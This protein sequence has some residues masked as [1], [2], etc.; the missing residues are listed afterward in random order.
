MSGRHPRLFRRAAFG[1]V[2]GSPFLIALYGAGCASAGEDAT[3]TQ[4]GA[5]GE[6]GIPGVRDSGSDSPDKADAPDGGGAQEGGLDALFAPV[7]DSC[8]DTLTLAPAR[9]APAS[10]EFDTSD[11]K[12]DYTSYCTKG[13]NLEPALDGVVAISPQLDPGEAGTLTI[14]ATRSAGTA[15]L[16]TQSECGQSET[17]LSCG[18]ADLT[19]STQLAV[20]EGD[21]V[22]AVAETP[23]GDAGSVTVKAELAPA[24][25]GDGALNQGEGCDFGDT[26][27]DD[28]CDPDCQFEAPAD[29]ASDKCPGTP[30]PVNLSLTQTFETSG[31]TI[32]Y[33]DDYDAPCSDAKGAPE[34]VFSVNVDASGTLRVTVDADFD[35]VVS[36]YDSCVSEA[37]VGARGCTDATDPT[38]TE[39][40]QVPAVSGAR[41][42]IVV[43][44]FNAS[45][46]GTFSLKA[47]LVEAGSGDAGADGGDAGALDAGDGG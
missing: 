44:G 33:S 19:T 7:G 3:G 41:Y 45:S 28:G 47:E 39:V 43:D 6:A 27:P 16:Y 34:R 30:S 26:E 8:A 17:V 38:A 31:F 32:G 12:D 15:I 5:G 40:L 29:A 10:I 46:M 25:C 23:A 22:Y 20:T 36:V 35:A 24:V 18:V 37:L 42:L 1:A 9:G 13:G 4:N 14:T 11:L 21:V 2:L